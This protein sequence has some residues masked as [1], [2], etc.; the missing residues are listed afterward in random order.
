MFSPKFSKFISSEGRIH[1]R[2]FLRGGP[3]SVSDEKM[4]DPHTDFMITVVSRFRLFSGL[5]AFFINFYFSNVH[6]C[7]FE[8]NFLSLS[9]FASLNNKFVCFLC[10][11]ICSNGQ[12]VIVCLLSHVCIIKPEVGSLEEEF[13]VGSNIGVRGPDCGLT[14]FFVCHLQ[15]WI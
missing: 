4:T 6:K 12:F 13:E 15:G 11:L 5:I 2:Y 8:H 7:F 1:I 3:G 10:Q 9:L 14:K